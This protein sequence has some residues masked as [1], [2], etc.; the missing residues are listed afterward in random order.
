MKYLEQHLRRLAWLDERLASAKGV[1]AL[2]DAKKLGFS[3]KT[4][5][6]DL[7]FLHE[8]SPLVYVEEDF[9]H[10]R[11]FYAD[12]RRRIFSRWFAEAARG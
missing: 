10:R 6:R 12:R 8:L 11:W 1:S 3:V 5:R 7:E 4:L 2:R 9:G